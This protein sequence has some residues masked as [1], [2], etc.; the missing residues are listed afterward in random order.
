[1]ENKSKSPLFINYL[2]FNKTTVGWLFVFIGYMFPFREQQIEIICFH[3]LCVCV[4][5]T[6][7]RWAPPLQDDSSLSALTGVGLQ[8]VTQTLVTVGATGTEVVHAGSVPRLG[9]HHTMAGLKDGGLHDL[10]A[11]VSPLFGLVACILT[12]VDV[13][14]RLTGWEGVAAVFYLN[15]QT[16]VW[17]M[18]H[19]GLTAFHSVCVFI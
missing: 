19:W 18:C 17:C 14:T 10:T 5:L 3:G 1:M 12:W 4:L 2:E 6:T 7:Q 13:L 11:S 8:C 16:V 15:Q 9:W